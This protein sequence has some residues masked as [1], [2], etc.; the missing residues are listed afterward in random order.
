[1]GKVSIGLRGWRFDE[2]D[3][4]TADGSLKPLA[5]MPED[6]RDRVLRLAGLVEKPCDACWLI[7]GEEEKRRCRS[8][9][10]VYGEPL[11]EVLLCAHHEPDF[12][13]WFREEGGHELAGHRELQN[14]FH[15][16]FADGGRAP[17]DYEGTEHVETDPDSIPEPSHEVAPLEEELAAMSEEERAA[18]GID[19]SDLDVDR[20]VDL[21]V[22]LDPDADPD[23]TV[24]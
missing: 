12:V 17:E 22:D 15:E 23:E 18:L 14:A 19:L 3:V 11:G 8:A 21:D 20:D 7:H 4:L 10:V 16:W 9:Q 6:A 24:D 5:N 1:M 2:A 13:Y